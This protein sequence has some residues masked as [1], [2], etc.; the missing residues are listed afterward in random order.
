MGKHI[1]SKPPPS[2]HKIYY[3]WSSY[4]IPQAYDRECDIFLLAEQV[5]INTSNE[6][7]QIL[8]SEIDF[9]VLSQPVALIGST[10]IILEV[11]HLTWR[12]IR[13]VDKETRL[14][15]GLYLFSF[16]IA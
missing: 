4:I 13:R 10:K 6:S 16:T 1:Y 15:T 14:Q 3:D 8:K 5:K 12:L 9:T 11:S 7:R 2:L